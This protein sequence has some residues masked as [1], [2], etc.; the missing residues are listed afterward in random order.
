MHLPADYPR[1]NQFP[2]W[3]TVEKVVH[4]GIKVN[5]GS[6]RVVMGEELASGIPLELEAGRA[7]VVEIGL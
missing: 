2:E 4:Y 3:F 6:K 1:I 5:S 7:L